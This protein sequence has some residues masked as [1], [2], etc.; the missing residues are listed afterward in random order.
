MQ[1][2]IIAAFI[3]GLIVLFPVGFLASFIVSH[4]IS[5]GR[6]REARDMALAI[7]GGYVFLWLGTLVGMLVYASVR[8]LM[9][10]WKE[11][12]V[13]PAPPP[14]TSTPLTATAASAPAIGCLGGTFIGVALMGGLLVQ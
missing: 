7:F 5:I 10:D 11:R 2:K 12:A 3:Y 4:G 8:D 1:S 6:E 14:V 13:T 9:K